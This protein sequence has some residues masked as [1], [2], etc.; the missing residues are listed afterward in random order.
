VEEGWLRYDSVTGETLLISDFAHLVLELSELEGDQ[1]FEELF[2]SL[3]RELPDL[4][5]SEISSALCLALDSLADI[6]LI[7]PL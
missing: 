5:P 1:D 6:G 4:Q 2:A 7:R 3:C